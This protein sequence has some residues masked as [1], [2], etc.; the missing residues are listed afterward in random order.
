MAIEIK[1]NVAVI[2]ESGKFPFVTALGNTYHQELYNYVKNSNVVVSQTEFNALN[3]LITSLKTLNVWNG[4]TEFFPL[5]GNT[6]NSQMV[7]L[8]SV[9]N[10][11]AEKFNSISDS[12]TDGKGLYY[13]TQVTTSAKAL[14]LGVTNQNLY[15]SNTGFGVIAYFKNN[16]DSTVNTL[17]SLFGQ[18]ALLG[19]PIAGDFCM[20]ISDDTKVIYERQFSSTPTLA[21]YT[22]E[23]QLYVSKIVWNSSKQASQRLFR[24]NGSVLLN[25]S[26]V[27]NLTA[28]THT[29]FL[30][31]GAQ[32]VKDSATNGGYGW[33]GNIRLFIM[34]DGTMDEAKIPQVETAINT[35]IFESGKTL[36]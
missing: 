16:T 34:H 23:I 20:Q 6:I 10:T 30:L 28:P 14:K 1:S 25:S 3:N 4:I 5:M 33:V 29:D 15:A 24:S 2:D 17:R 13:A 9:S 12:F 26:S 21:N 35:F 27:V 8:K 31:L 36:S 7:K 11:V 32:K 18:T 22:S 19:T